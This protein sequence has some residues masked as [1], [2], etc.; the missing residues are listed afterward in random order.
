VPAAND[1]PTGAL[2]HV[3]ESQVSKISCDTR[4]QGAAP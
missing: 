3:N 2:N 1:I 4:I